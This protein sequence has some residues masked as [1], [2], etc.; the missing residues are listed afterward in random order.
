LGVGAGIIIGAAINPFFSPRIYRRTCVRSPD[1]K[2]PPEVRLVMGCAGGV[3]VPVGMFWFAWTSFPSIHWI[4]PILAGVPFGMGMLFIFVSTSA[5][6]MDTYTIYCA[7]AIAASVLL[8]SVVAAV[9]PLFTP[10]LVASLE[11]QW[12]LTIFALLSLP[13]TPPP[14][15]FYIYGPRIRAASRFS[16]SGILRRQKSQTHNPRVDLDGENGP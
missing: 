8:R 11:T 9:F 3:L 4:V 10:Y 13:C 16:H 15:L 12:A 5:Y 2:A 1:G 14:F 7:S 6:F